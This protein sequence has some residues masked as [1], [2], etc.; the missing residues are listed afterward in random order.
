MALIK[1]KIEIRDEGGNE[2]KG[3]SVN[4]KSSTPG[5]DIN[6]EF[7]KPLVSFSISNPFRKILYWLDQ[8]RKKQT[9]T[10]AFKV[11][12]PLIALPVFIFAL[13]QVGKWS[14]LTF[15]R[16]QSATPVASASPTVT[17]SPSPVIHIEVSKA[18]TLK[19]AKGASQT[20]YLLSLRNGT[21]VPLEIPE[22]I[23]LSKY[24][25]K[26]VLVTGLQ[27][28]ET[29]VISVTDIAEVEVFNVTEIPK[30]TPVSS[31]SPE[32]TGSAN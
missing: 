1:P 22:S 12:V 4:I 32:A 31:A 14:G 24:T 6:P 11:S 30:A 13:F 5:S 2:I 8:I 17:G 15:T 20:R 28:K 25:N 29:G 27:N 21:L 19:V 26:Q 3:A 10:F 18:G 9:T 16:F 7:E 23:N